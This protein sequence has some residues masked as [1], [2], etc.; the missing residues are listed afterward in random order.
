MRDRLLEIQKTLYDRFHASAQNASGM[1]HPRLGAYFREYIKEFTGKARPCTHDE[2]Q[3]AFLESDLL[4]CGDYHTLHQAQRTALELLEQGVA[5]LRRRGRSLVL[6]VEMLGAQDAEAW[7]AYAAGESDDALFLRAVQWKK[8]WDFPWENYRPL[9]H[10]AKQQGARVLGLRRE[11]PPSTLRDRDRHAARVLANFL[12]ENPRSTVLALVGDL[13]LAKN[14]LPFE[15]RQVCGRLGLRK[16]VTIVHQNAERFFWKGE[17]LHTQRPVWRLRDGV[18]CVLNTPPWIKA[19]SYL[20]WMEGQVTEASDLAEDFA[21]LADRIQS[22]LKIP[23]AG[24]CFELR[25]HPRA[26]ANY[27]EAFARRLPAYLRP[28]SGVVYLSTPDLTELSVQAA[29]YVHARLS[30][31]QW[32]FEI[33]QRDFYPLVWVEGLGFLGSKLLNPSRHPL[34]RAN[35]VPALVGKT[36]RPDPETAAGYW[37]QARALGESLGEKLYGGLVAG[38]ISLDAIQA[39]FRQSF[40]NSISAQKMFFAWVSRL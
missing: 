32:E 9:F 24:E 25:W 39:L 26:A 38:K 16:R 1:L 20:D 3:N 5:P 12:A 6:A 22:L 21:L 7:R 10:W 29:I 30:G 23:G 40:S 34:P 33:P 2:L 31:R 14:H 8:R 15:V 37:N 19:R 36:S 27:A 11:G 35:A 28:T 13:H 18:Y 17:A 4:I